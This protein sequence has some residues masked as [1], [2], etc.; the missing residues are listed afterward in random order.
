MGNQAAK[1]DKRDKEKYPPQEKERLERELIC[2]IHRAVPEF[3]NP[4][5]RQCARFVYGQAILHLGTL[6][7]LCLTG[8]PKQ[9]VQ[10]F[11]K[12]HKGLW[13]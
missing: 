10:Y 12:E 3:D 2:I 1:G 4:T 8:E 9:E 6:R 7:G 11:V 13:T 5:E